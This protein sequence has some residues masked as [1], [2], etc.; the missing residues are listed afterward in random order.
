MKTDHFVKNSE[1]ISLPYHRLTDNGA[2]FE[3]TTECEEAFQNLK[4]SLISSPILSYPKPAHPFIL[5]TD[6][7]HYAVGAVLSQAETGVE[8]VITYMSKALNKHGTSYCVT[9]KELLAVVIALKTFHSYLYGQ[10]VFMR[11]DNTTVS[12][13]RNL[14]NVPKSKFGNKYFLTICD[15]FTKWIEAVP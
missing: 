5:D 9:R 3:W 6:A 12:W 13:M 4:G 10:H 7:S 11:I 14:R 8:H 1:D 2:K 15:C